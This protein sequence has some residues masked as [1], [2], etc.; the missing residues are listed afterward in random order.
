M[1]TTV[2]DR[3]IL[4][5]KSQRISV[6]KFEKVC[7]F[8]TGYVANMRKSLQPD[9]ILSI[10]QNFPKLNT[11]W[12][13]TGEGEMLKEQKENITKEL[14]EINNVQNSNTEHSTIIE[15]LKKDVKYY[16]DIAD[17]RLQTINV[18]NTLIEN[19]GKLINVM[20]KQLN[21]K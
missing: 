4:F 16:A 15:M 18:Q 11:A 20:E 5:I 17:S 13:F 1:E 12:L 2:K 21:L 6:N 7:G 14:Q 9:K 19:M 8:S 3:L 10:V